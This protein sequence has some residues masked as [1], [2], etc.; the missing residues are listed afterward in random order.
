MIVGVAAGTLILLGILIFIWRM[1]QNKHD[2]EVQKNNNAHEL[3]VVEMN[4]HTSLFRL[5]ETP[6]GQ[7]LLAG[8][9]EGGPN[10]LAIG[11]GTGPYA[12]GSG[13]RVFDVRQG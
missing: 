13:G 2:L 9:L 1:R 6:Q 11:A 10:R 4:S 8:F 3:Q 12:G 7:R 5:A